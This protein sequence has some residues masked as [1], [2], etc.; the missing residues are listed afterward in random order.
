MAAAKNALTAA[1]AA[2]DT[3]DLII[4]ATTTPRRGLS[5]HGLPRAGALGCRGSAAFD[6]QAVCSGFVYALGTADGLIRAGSYKRALVIGAETLS[7]VV[8]WEDRS[9]CV[10]FGDGAAAVVLEASDAPRDPRAPHARP[11]ERSEP[12]RSGLMRTSRGVL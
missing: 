4:V 8:N 9:T 1:G 10:L 12:T 11:T 2:A 3:V 6:V 7:R 5:F